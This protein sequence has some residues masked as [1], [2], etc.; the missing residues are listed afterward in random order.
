MKY[1]NKENDSLAENVYLILKTKILEM[2][3]R[4]GETLLIQTI[5]RDLDISRTPVREALVRLRQEGLVEDAPGRKMKVCTLSTKD[6]WEIYQIREGLEGMA[7]YIAASQANSKH[8]KMLENDIRLSVEATNNENYELFFEN[9]NNFHKHIIEITGNTQMKNILEKLSSRIERIRY[10]TILSR[11]RI[12][13]SKREHTNVLECIKKKDSSGA[14]DAME[15]H[16][17]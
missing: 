11:D 5:A 12:Q 10:V 14:R 8:I 2:E 15:E 13:N 1:N 6:I 3:L 17:K 4:P 7:S 9:D 16:L